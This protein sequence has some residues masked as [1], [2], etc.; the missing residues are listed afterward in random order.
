M[1]TG[2]IIG[3]VLIALVIILGIDIMRSHRK[4]WEAHDQ[5]KKERAAARESE[6][7]AMYDSV[8]ANAMAGINAAAVHSANQVSESIA[9]ARVAHAK[10]QAQ[11]RDNLA[12]YEKMQRA[13]GMDQAKGLDQATHGSPTAL[14]RRISNPGQVAAKLNAASPSYSEQEARRM[15]A[16]DRAMIDC[17]IGGTG[18]VQMTAGEAKHIPR[19]EFEQEYPVKT[20]RDAEAEMMATVRQ[21]EAGGSIDSS[22]S[23][24]SSA[25]STSD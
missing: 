1:E 25:S 23:S 21:V 16:I 8:T 18:M 10:A 9:A 6:L 12:A 24:N 20:R 17:M 11:E 7:Q 22:T 3:L 5:K 13:K 4:A 15:L 2:H 19:S 14:G